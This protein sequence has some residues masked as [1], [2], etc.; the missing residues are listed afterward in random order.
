MTW[1]AKRMEAAAKVKAL[2]DAGFSSRDI[3]EAAK[4][5]LIDELLE[6]R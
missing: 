3:I 2:R 1:N 4:A 5:G 6:D